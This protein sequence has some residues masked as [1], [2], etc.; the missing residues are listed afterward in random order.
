VQDAGAHSWTLASGKQQ[1]AMGE[2][3]ADYL[4]S[5]IAARANKLKKNVRGCWAAWDVQSN[6][7]PSDKCLRRVNL[8]GTVSSIRRKC[9]SGD[10]GHC[11]G[12]VWS[13]ALWQIRAKN[14][15]K[16][17]DKTLLQSHFSYSASTGFKKGARAFL[18]AA[19]RLS[20]RK[21]VR[22]ARRIFCKRRIL[23]SRKDCRR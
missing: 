10:D 3:D 20:K 7:D 11:L 23:T 17:T 1:L 12:Q 4:A 5:T 18:K 6:G 2:G 15:V 13:G 22:R 8:K 19:R 21:H 16:R 9:G 14:G